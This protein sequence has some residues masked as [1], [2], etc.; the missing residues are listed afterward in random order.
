MESGDRS[1][2]K[3][4]LGDLLLQVV[5]QSQ[6]CREEGAFDFHDV[7]Q[8]ISDKLIR[9]HPHIFADAEAETPGDVVRHWEA[10]KQVE[11]GGEK[12]SVL[13]GV[14]RSM[15]PLPRAFQLQRKA[16]RVG[17]DWPDVHGVVGKVAE[18]LCEVEEALA[19]EDADAL[20]EELGDL[21]F[22]VVNLCRF[23][24]CDADEALRGAMHKFERRFRCVEQAVEEAG[25]A[26]Q[27]C[28]PEELDALWNEVKRAEKG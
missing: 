23:S 22:A 24:G 1:A 25:R 11:R 16:A 9:R 19:A 15:P 18:E 5:F 26:M 20:K 10:I 2:L 14:P 21:L 28:P 13:A 7:A 8:A 27:D 6:L 4:E 17:F 12:R 3:D